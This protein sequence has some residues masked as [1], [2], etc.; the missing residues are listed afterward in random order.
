MGD[1]GDRGRGGHP[2]AVGPI[3]GR[4]HGAEVGTEGEASGE[5]FF[6]VVVGLD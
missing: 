6:H 5:V 1:G 4:I 3:L 2:R